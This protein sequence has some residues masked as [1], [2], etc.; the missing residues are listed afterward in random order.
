MAKMNEYPSVDDQQAFTPAQKA[1]FLGSAMCIATGSKTQ[2]GAKVTANIPLT[3][4]TPV[5]PTKL[6]DLTDDITQQTVVANDT[7]PVSGAA[8]NS[9][10][11]SFGGFQV[12]TID[13]NTQKPAEANPDPKVIYLTPSGESGTENSYD[14]WICTDTSVPT[15]EKVGV[16]RVDLNQYYTKT[17]ANAAFVSSTGYIAVPSTDNV[18]N[19]YLLTKTANGVQ[20]NE[21]DREHLL[22]DGAGITVY[23]TAGYPERVSV[24]YDSNTLNVNGSN[25]LNVKLPVPPISGITDGYV[26]TK[27]TTNNVDE[28]VWAASQGGGSS[29]PP[30]TSSDVGKV[31]GVKQEYDDDPITLDWMP[32]LPTDTTD[33]G[34][35]ACYYGG[36]AELKITFDRQT[37]DPIYD[38]KN[39]VQGYDIKEWEGNYAQSQDSWNNKD[40]TTWTTS[41]QN[42]TYAI[43]STI[44]K[45]EIADYDDV[46]APTRLNI[47]LRRSLL[48]PPNCLIEF[49][50]YTDNAIDVYIGQ[51][52]SGSD[53]A[54]DEVARPMKPVGETYTDEHKAPA[55]SFVS[56]QIIGHGYTIKYR[57][58][59]QDEMSDIEYGLCQGNASVHPALPT[60][61]Y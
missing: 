12:T 4:I 30:Y 2:N 53:W 31:L 28:V 3:D 54:D 10:L 36:G 13:P 39:S 32:G 16:T 8:V 52:N 25:E 49:A 1:A 57:P 40:T 33:L 29:L 46:V 18:N 5:V 51:Q 59:T 60:T 6:S 34:S 37:G 22:R 23:G 9:A 24:K 38:F 14:E 17:E 48:T 58:L 19:G 20:W 21:M 56:I 45:D 35:G 42:N 43:L 50:N 47:T 26:L 7:R 44:N 27:T 41:I 55:L 15:W 61:Y 11:A